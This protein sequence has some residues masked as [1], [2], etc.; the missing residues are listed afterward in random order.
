MNTK[1]ESTDSALDAHLAYILSIAGASYVA[2]DSEIMKHLRAALGAAVSELEPMGSRLNM[3]DAQ[4]ALAAKDAEIA[5]L[6]SAWQVDTV[7]RKDGIIAQQEAEND[8]LRAE[9]AAMTVERDALVKQMTPATMND[10]KNQDWRGMDGACA[11]HLIERHAENWGDAGEMM[12][13]W[14]AARFAPVVAQRDAL[15]A[16]VKLGA[17]A[18]PVLLTKNQIHLALDAAGVMP[19]GLTFER[20]LRVARAIEAAVHA[21][22]PALGSEGCAA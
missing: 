10:G 20:E 15:A 9:L 12:E 8:R 5:R 21:A 13:A 17:Q 19:D 6:E 14:A 18:A 7:R 11:H 3:S 2:A 22:N 16:K 4:A 1:N